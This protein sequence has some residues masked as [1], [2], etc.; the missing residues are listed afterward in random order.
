[1]TSN[2]LIAGDQSTV[3]KEILSRRGIGLRSHESV[4][5]IGWWVK[6]KGWFKIVW[7]GRIFY[8]CVTFENFYLEGA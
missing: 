1:M 5:V 8:V 6:G 4:N 7:G 2:V 3:F